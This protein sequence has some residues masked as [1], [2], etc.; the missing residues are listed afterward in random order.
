MK[1]KT[2]DI[3]GTGKYTKLKTTFQKVYCINI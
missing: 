1:Y 2:E 3:G